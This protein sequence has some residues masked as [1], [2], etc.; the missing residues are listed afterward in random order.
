MEIDRAQILLFFDSYG[1]R[2]LKNYAKEIDVLERDVLKL[3]V[4]SNNSN[5]EELLKLKLK[6]INACKDIEKIINNRIDELHLPYD[7]YKNLPRYYQEKRK[8]YKKGLVKKGINLVEILYFISNKIKYFFG[9]NS[10][11]HL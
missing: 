10:T 7:V 4:S 9:R 5:S 6:L 1:F 8:P 3:K 11:L 2:D